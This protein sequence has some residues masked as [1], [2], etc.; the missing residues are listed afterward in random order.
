MQHPHR[1]LA[2]R[3]FEEI[4]N[5]RRLETADELL[6]PEIR[7]HMEGQEVNSPQEFRVVASEILTALPD[8][9]IVVEDVIA[10]DRA[11]VV[12]WHFDATHTGHGLGCSPTQRCV[13]CTGMT[14]FEFRDG[15]IIE[16]WDRWNQT[17]LMQQL[18]APVAAQQARQT[19]F[20]GI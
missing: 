5:Q 13:T 4:W 7:G 19:S 1:E 17:A 18:Q 15:K 10:D 20:Q 3:W 12:R 11:A 9:R 2:L 14:W 16:G 8:L 6:H